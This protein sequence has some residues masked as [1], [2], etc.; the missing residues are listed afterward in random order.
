MYPAP[1]VHGAFLAACADAANA[2]GEVSRG[3]FDE[4]LERRAGCVRRE[5]LCQSYGRHAVDLLTV[6]DFACDADELRAR[7][8][9]VVSGRVHVVSPVCALA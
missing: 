2:A 4:L 5:T 1:H 8:V 9:A 6:S 7:K 3:A